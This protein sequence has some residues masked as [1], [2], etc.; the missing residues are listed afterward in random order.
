MCNWKS[1]THIYI[2][3]GWIQVTSDVTL[4]NVTPHNIF[5]IKCEF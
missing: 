1:G 2:Y 4:N 3:I 5:L